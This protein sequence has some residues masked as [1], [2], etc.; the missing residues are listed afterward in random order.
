MCYLLA[1]HCDR[2]FITPLSTSTPQE[3]ILHL[4]LA[5]CLAIRAQCAPYQYIND[6]C[7]SK[8]LGAVTCLHLS[9]PHL[10]LHWTTYEA[11]P[12]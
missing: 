2:T 5:V 8:A 1:C 6:S 12:L 3:R 9:L 11:G 10:Q 4:A 7:W